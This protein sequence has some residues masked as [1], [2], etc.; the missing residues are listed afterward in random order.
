MTIK[1]IV[2]AMVVATVTS[3]AAMLA[4]MPAIELPGETRL[5]ANQ[6]VA[7]NLD[8]F[9]TTAERQN[10]NNPQVLSYQALAGCSKFRAERT[11]F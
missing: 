1:T 5:A 8:K 2:F 6:G 10:E 9:R 4:P 7:V 3:L 11:G